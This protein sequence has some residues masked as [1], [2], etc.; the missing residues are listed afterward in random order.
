MCGFGLGK[1][2]GGRE[3]GVNE[4]GSDIADTATGPDEEMR[5]GRVDKG[6]GGLGLESLGGGIGG[7]ALSTLEFL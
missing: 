2:N 7:G 6:A 5:L 3:S 4:E 1:P